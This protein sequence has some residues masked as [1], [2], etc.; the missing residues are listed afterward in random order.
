MLRSKWQGGA[1]QWEI[2][3]NRCVTFH[4]RLTKIHLF[5]WKIQPWSNSWKREMTRENFMQGISQ[6]ESTP[7]NAKDREATVN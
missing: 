1:C 4:E 2:A 3:S 6:V 7:K 5:K